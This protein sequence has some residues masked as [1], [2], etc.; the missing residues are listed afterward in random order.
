M[1]ASLIGPFPT[2]V[3]LTD[4]VGSWGSTDINTLTRLVRFV[5]QA[6]IRKVQQDE[7]TRMGMTPLPTFSY[8]LGGYLFA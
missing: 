1:R 5:P 4:D 8:E 3:G 7:G 2:R 6:A